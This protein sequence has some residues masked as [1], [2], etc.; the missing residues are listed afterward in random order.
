MLALAGVYGVVSAAVA[1]RRR[2][3]AIRVALGANRSTVVM[4]LA[5]HGTKLVAVG[6]SSGLSAAVAA[7][8]LLASLMDGSGSGNGSGNDSGLYPSVVVLA[9]ATLLVIAA[10]LMACLI[11]A[12]RA[13]RTDSSVALR[14]T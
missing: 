9:V 5:G 12:L 7:S 13:S 4:L 2:E 10:S 3:I 11:P 1:R 14:E 8:R 6:C